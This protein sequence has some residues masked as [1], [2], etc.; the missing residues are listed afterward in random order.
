MKTKFS[1]LVAFCLLVVVIASSCKDGNAIK[2]KEEPELVDT[3]IWKLLG[4]YDVETSALIEAE[5]KDCK[6][7]YTLKYYGLFSGE[8]ND[9]D[10]YFFTGRTVVNSI[11]ITIWV[12]TTKRPAVS[13]TFM[14]CASNC[15]NA[16]LLYEALYKLDAL[17]MDEELLKQDTLKLYYNSHQN[18][19][20][21][22]KV[23]E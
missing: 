10:Y 8:C 9:C 12:D 7:C 5:P 3:T 4:F 23:T 1:L 17:T 13:H 15:G 14:G 22:K 18:Y 2:P 6:N 20:L 21:Y 11:E 16:H 19:L